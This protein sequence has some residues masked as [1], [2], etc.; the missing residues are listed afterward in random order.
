MVPIRSLPRKPSP[1]TPMAL[2]FSSRHQTLLSSYN[3]KHKGQRGF[4]IGGGTS[5]KYLQD[6]GFDF[7]RLKTEITVGVNKAYNLFVPTYLVFGDDFF[8]KHFSQEIRALRCVKFAPSQILRGYS[9]S[10]LLQLRT[11]T[12]YQE[13]LPRGLDASISFMNNSGV[14]ALRV[15]YCL[16]CNPIYLLGIDLTENN[17][18]ETHFHADYER[19]KRHTTPAK[20]KTFHTEFARTLSALKT[21][22]ISV[23]SC[24][25]I[26]SLNTI[27]PY[28]NPESL[29]KGVNSL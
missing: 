13:V 19:F 5:I 17:M 14:A 16:G 24:S 28:I 3:N 23:F 15:L 9:D 7:Q 18:G 29:Y 20:Y 12:N 27:I 26:S 22:N 6:S 10:S 2:P 11:S 21:K 1:K 25:S 4:L 8:W